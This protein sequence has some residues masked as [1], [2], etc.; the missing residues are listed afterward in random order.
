MDLEKAPEDGDLL[1]RVFRGFHTVKGGAGFLEIGVLVELCHRA[2]GLLD[3]LR[4][5]ELAL[6]ASLMDLILGAT[7]E[8]RRMFGELRA[9]GDAAPAPG[10][11][12]AGIDAALKGEKPAARP[13]AQPAG[14]G[15]DWQ[16]LYD[17]LLGKVTEKPQPVVEKPR[18]ATPQVTSP[19]DT[20]L[21]VDT[22][23]FDQIL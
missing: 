1:N 18:P 10:E 6:D 2:E 4:R 11:L 16:A 13:S 12:L 3:R 5:K 7:A 21:R 23:R 17:A 8:V 20:T 22:A 15:P 14:K 19:K 9:G